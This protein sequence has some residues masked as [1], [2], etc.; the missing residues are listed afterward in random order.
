M[1]SGRRRSAPGFAIGEAGG[2][3]QSWLSGEID[4]RV[5]D[6]TGLVPTQHR[7]LT[8]ARHYVGSVF[9][10]DEALSRLLPGTQHERSWLE[11]ESLFGRSSRRLLT[12]R[13]QLCALPCA[14]RTRRQA[15]RRREQLW[16][17]SDA[18]RGSRSAVILCIY[19][20]RGRM[21]Q[22]YSRRLR[23]LATMS[24]NGCLWS[25]R[26]STQIPQ[27]PDWQRPRLWEIIH[28]ELRIVARRLL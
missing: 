8:A 10:A 3:T 14:L 26:A 25:R 19:R 15:S 21:I 6:P 17:G 27:F 1:R 28:N 5:V 2:S 4:S 22:R 24:S 11:Y 18:G 23:E 9:R 13:P 7:K 12:F 20:F 16:R